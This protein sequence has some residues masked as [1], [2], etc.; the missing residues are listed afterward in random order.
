ELVGP[1]NQGNDIV[2]WRHPLRDCIYDELTECILRGK[3][4][5]ESMT[6]HVESLRQA[7]YPE[8]AGL[9]ESSVMVYDHM[10]PSV[11]AFL[12]TWWRLIDNGS[13]RDQLSFNPSL[14]QHPKVR[15][16]YFG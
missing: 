6:R 7:G 11:Q 15:L 9:I 3:D 14:W 4:D 2:T 13:R 8:K 1:E 10:K 12:A 16:G 5:P